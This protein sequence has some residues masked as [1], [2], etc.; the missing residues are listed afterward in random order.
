MG[1]LTYAQYCARRGYVPPFRGWSVVKRSLLDSWAQPGF[2]RFWRIWNPPIGYP[3]FRFYR[4]LGGNRNRAFATFTVFTVT[5]VLHD[6]AAFVLTRQWALALTLAYVVFA[7]LSL[8]SLRLAPLLRQE[9]WPAMVNV[10]MNGLLVVGTFEG[11]HRDSIG[12]WLPDR[13]TKLGV[14]RSPTGARAN[15]RLQRAR[16]ASGWTLLY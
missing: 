6:L 1:G 11:S 3:L 7:G 13:M 2:H 16:Y 9:R 12:T 15:K 4:V 14:A 10:L 8:L 5:G